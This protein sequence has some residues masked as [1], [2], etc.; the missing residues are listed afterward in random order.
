MTAPDDLIVTA[1]KE[2]KFICTAVTD[3]SMMDK[4]QIQWMKFSSII[5]MA[6]SGR[7]FQNTMDNSLT[8]TDVNAEDAALYSCMAKTALDSAK[9]SAF[10]RVRGECDQK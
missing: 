4:L 1:G 3:P 8:I 5:D 10:L 7:I 2:A 6:Q 9:A